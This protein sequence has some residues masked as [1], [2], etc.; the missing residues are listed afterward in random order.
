MSTDY[1]ITTLEQLRAVIPEASQLAASVGID[2]ATR[3]EAVRHPVVVCA[4][5]G[6]GAVLLPVD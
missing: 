5:H 4:K 3:R 2:S 6:Q 1:A